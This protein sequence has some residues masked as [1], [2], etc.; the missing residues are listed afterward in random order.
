MVDFDVITGPGPAALPSTAP[1]AAKDKA[2]S[3]KP[4]ERPREVPP[5]REVKRPG[6]P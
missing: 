1:A 2:A 5:T 6:S 3:G 4:E